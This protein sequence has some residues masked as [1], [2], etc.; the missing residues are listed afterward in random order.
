[1][2]FLN[3]KLRIP[4]CECL[5]RS[6][7]NQQSISRLSFTDKVCCEFSPSLGLCVPLEI[8]ETLQGP[9]GMH[10]FKRINQFL[11]PQLYMTFSYNWSTWRTFLCI[12]L[13]FHSYLTSACSP[14]PLRIYSLLLLYKRKAYFSPI[15][16]LSKV[17][18]PGV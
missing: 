9:D 10:S 14:A 12:I 4:F 3:I 15:L 17:H 11:K 18:C 13:I 16:N 6:I 2:S 7:W 5:K 8:H 1:M